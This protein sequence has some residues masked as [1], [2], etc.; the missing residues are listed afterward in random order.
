MAL[1]FKNAIASNGGGANDGVIEGWDNIED[2]DVLRDP[3]ATVIGAAEDREE[4][5]A[6]DG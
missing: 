2:A 1:P 4:T 5:S 6:L 3:E